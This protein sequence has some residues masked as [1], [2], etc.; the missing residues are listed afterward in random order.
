M[1]DELNRIINLQG[2]S[3]LAE[4]QENNTRSGSYSR[5]KVTRN[6][7]V[8]GSDNVKRNEENKGAETRNGEQNAHKGDNVPVTRTNS[9]QR[10]SHPNKGPQTNDNRTQGT[11]GQAAQSKVNQGS[12]T[13][14]R[15]SN[16]GQ[17]AQSRPD[18]EQEVQ[19]RGPQGQGTHGRTGSQKRRTTYP[20]TNM[21]HD[22]NK[23]EKRDR[24]YGRNETIETV[25]DI[26][27]DIVRIQKEIDLEI[28]EIR[29]L[30]L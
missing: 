18:H 27:E 23:P 9:N 4:R 13:Q 10:Q 1:P 25:D 21:Y 15:G 14:G 7:P 30:K 6:N 20:G 3:K 5:G 29:S 22:Q 24:F 12:R 11:Q 2:G 17:A 19:N 28:K 8:K 16:R 26:K